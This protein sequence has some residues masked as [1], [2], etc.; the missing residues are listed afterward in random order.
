[1]KQLHQLNYH[2]TAIIDK[3]DE[4]YSNTTDLP[5]GELELRLL[6]MG[7]IP[8]ARLHLVSRGLFGHD[9]LAFKL[10]DSGTIMALR[11]NEASAILLKE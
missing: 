3:I 1:M 7:F 9:P 4:S 8:G 10:E 2:I 5:P 11:R 6:E